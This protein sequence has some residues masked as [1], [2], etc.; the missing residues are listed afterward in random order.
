MKP[1]CKVV[2]QNANAETFLKVFFPP[3]NFIKICIYALKPAS[4]ETRIVKLV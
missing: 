2:Y 1:Y 3:L 4:C